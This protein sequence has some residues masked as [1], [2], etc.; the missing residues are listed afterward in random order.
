MEVTEVYDLPFESSFDWRSGLFNILNDFAKE[1]IIEILS[2]YKESAQKLE[3]KDDDGLLNFALDEELFE[4][5]HLL[6]EK[7]AHE[8]FI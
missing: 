6:M 2:K 5:I 7:K 3:W 1:S 8:S 4:K